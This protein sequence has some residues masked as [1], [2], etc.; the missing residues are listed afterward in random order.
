MS[1][2]MYLHFCIASMLAVKE[3]NNWAKVIQDNKVV[4]GLSPCIPCRHRV[5]LLSVC[6]L[7]DF[8][9]APMCYGYQSNLPT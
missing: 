7:S 8:P 4:G 1:R 6:L 9:L 5:L 2:L 3:M